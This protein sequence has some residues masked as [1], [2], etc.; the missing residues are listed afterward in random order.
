[1]GRLR[2][3]TKSAAEKINSG[4]R[5]TRPP[6]SP[7]HKVKTLRKTAAESV[8][9]PCGL[10][11]FALNRHLALA[12]TGRATKT[13]VTRFRKPRGKKSFPH[14][15]TTTATCVTGVLVEQGL[16]LRWSRD[17]LQPRSV[18]RSLLCLVAEGATLVASGVVKGA[19]LTRERGGLTAVVVNSRCNLK[20][21][22][23]AWC[24]HSWASG[25]CRGR[26]AAYPD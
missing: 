5:I 6:P 17:Y 24:T 10:P 23:R 1:M 11:A 26:N 25:S 4:F 18:V 22:N 12:K 16:L 3:S 20:Q 8:S 13:G 15:K 7:T 2:G 21:L 14:T 9:A 19:T